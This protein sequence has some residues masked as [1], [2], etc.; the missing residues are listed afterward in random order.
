MIPQ[1]ESPMNSYFSSSTQCPA[2]AESLI[3]S[4]MEERVLPNDSV[5]FT[6]SCVSLIPNDVSIKQNVFLFS[7]DFMDVRLED[8]DMGGDGGERG[9]LWRAI[10]FNIYGFLSLFSS[11]FPSVRVP[12]VTV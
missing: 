9:M 6:A 11:F 7:L 1:I 2:F 3:Q 4:V 5:T 12:L 10:H 8:D